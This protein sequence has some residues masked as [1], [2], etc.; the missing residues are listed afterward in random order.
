MDLSK[1]FDCLP[2]CLLIANLHAYSV[3]LSACDPLPDYQSLHLQRAKIE[4]ARSSWTELTK[5]VLKAQ[6]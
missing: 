3:D 5:G 6:F 2:H 4:T 1:A